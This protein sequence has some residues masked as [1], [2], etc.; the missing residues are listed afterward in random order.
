MNMQK[1]GRVSVAVWLFNN[2]KY[3]LKINKLRLTPYTLCVFHIQ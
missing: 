1:L 3:L 2:I